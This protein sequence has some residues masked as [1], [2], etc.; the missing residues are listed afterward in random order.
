MK[1]ELQFIKRDV[2]GHHSPECKHSLVSP[3]SVPLDEEF[4]DFSLQ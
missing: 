2:S 3:H 1:F 4:F